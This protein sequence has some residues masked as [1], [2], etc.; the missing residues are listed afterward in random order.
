[1]SP[2]VT[3]LMSTY[4]GEKYL[5][6]SIESVLNQTFSDFEFL[7]IDDGSTDKS[8]NIILD[9][10]DSRI[11]YL[12]NKVNLGLTKSLNKGLKLTKGKYIARQDA[13][14]VSLPRRLH[15]Q[16]LFMENHSKV[17]ICGSWIKT[18]SNE[19]QSIG[20][21]PLDHNKII[22]QL[23]FETAIYHPT[24]IMRK[25]AIIN[26]KLFYDETF[27]YSQ[28]YLLWVL[29]SQHFH[30]ANIGQVLVNCRKHDNQIN[31]LNKESQDK[32]A[33]KV[34]LLQ[35]H[36]LNIKPLDKEFAL[37]QSI[38]L[39]KFK[40][41]KEYIFSANQWMKKLIRKN[42][43]L[44]IYPEQEFSIVLFEK[45]Y[46]ICYQA[47]VNGFWVLKTFWKSSLSK[48]IKLSLRKKIILFLRCAFQ[49]ESKITQ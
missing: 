43:D 1:M 34:R 45:W 23:I 39:W 7:I 21:T 15:K 2:R 42:S 13:D 48:N 16:I 12:E 24:V 29:C 41:N 14:D 37:H 25:N 47:T 11:K 3:V 26:N 22:C 44:K 20:K 28:D 4:N 36:K 46:E 30:L 38:S 17:G 8:R 32:F 40:K 35:I 9:Y 18:F 49:L 33:D 31:A 27:T 6:E 5:R 10:D 19:D